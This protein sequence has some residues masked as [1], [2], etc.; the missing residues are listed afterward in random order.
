MNR[1]CVK[2]NLGRLYQSNLFESVVENFELLHGQVSI[3]FDNDP[4]N[5]D[6]SG[7]ASSHVDHECFAFE[8]S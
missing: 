5:P 1:A 7:R 2:G 4:P 6:A 3:H 8:D